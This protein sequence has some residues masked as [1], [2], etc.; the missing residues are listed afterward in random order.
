METW[1]PASVWIALDVHKS[2]LLLVIGSGL[3][4]LQ[5]LQVSLQ[6]SGSRSNSLYNQLKQL[7]KQ[8]ENTSNR[9]FSEFSQSFS[10]DLSKKSTIPG[11]S[12]SC[13]KT[14]LMNSAHLPAT[15][16]FASEICAGNSTSLQPNKRK[17]NQQIVNPKPSKKTKAPQ[18]ICRAL[19]CILQPS[20]IIRFEN[21]KSKTIYITLKSLNPGGRLVGVVICIGEPTFM[22]RSTKTSSH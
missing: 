7:I 10:G 17:L 4:W 22:V 8:A 6:H 12:S 14:T 19:E 16:L 5:L 15:Y 20:L 11:E 3:S 13:V 18:S 1:I 2:C 9:K 21:A